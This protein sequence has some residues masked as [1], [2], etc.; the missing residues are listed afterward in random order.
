[1]RGQWR[2]R[3]PRRDC[4]Y[5]STDGSITYSPTLA[6]STN[7]AL[8]CQEGTIA[9]TPSVSI[10]NVF[11][12]RC[13]TTINEQVG[14]AGLTFRPMDT[15]RI[16][17]DFQFGYN[18]AAYVRTG[19]RQVQ[20]Y[21][22]H[23]NYKPRPWITI[24]GSVDIHENRDN[25]TYVNDLEHGRTYGF[26]TIFARNSNLAFTVGYNY[27]DISLQDMIA[28]RDNF[29]SSLTI[30]PPYDAL[31]STGYLFYTPGSAGTAPCP[32][33]FASATGDGSGTNASIN[34]CTTAFYTS[35]QHY[36][37]SDVMWKP[38]KRITAS[39]GFSGT[40]VG[41]STVFLNPL[42][43]GGT[44]AFNYLKPFAS[45][46]IDIYK[47]LSYSTT[48]NYY[49][50][51]SRSPVNVSVTIPAGSGAYAGQAYSLQPITP[52]DFNGSTL[53]FSMRYAF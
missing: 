17:A 13:S 15:L 48:W 20:S 44:L 32:T 45:L 18:D 43:P 39:L 6:G 5:N 46:Q 8:Y 42:Q 12:G 26:T 30:S 21:K 9:A 49:A 41:G 3:L 36:A 2:E 1:M 34:L 47:G 19:P 50:Y 28:F 52:P 37:Y 23:A 51:D 31:T 14:L 40:F 11:L 22:I 33:G 25:V 7:T 29:S 4:A 24:D 35:R 10:T 53:M 16:Y 38:F 27:S